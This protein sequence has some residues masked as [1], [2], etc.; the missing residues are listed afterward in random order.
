MEK[1][2]SVK[3]AITGTLLFILVG[4]ASYLAIMLLFGFE[5]FN[6]FR[7]R[8]N[9]SE[10][11]SANFWSFWT[12]LFLYQVMNFIGFNTG[13]NWLFPV[14]NFSEAEARDR[15]IIKYLMLAGLCLG[16]LLLILLRPDPGFYNV[17]V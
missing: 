3:L 8:L 9:Q 14:A 15:S 13:F 7:N 5:I 1:L 16:T 10:L 6:F 11:Y 12:A 4:T 2:N 17:A